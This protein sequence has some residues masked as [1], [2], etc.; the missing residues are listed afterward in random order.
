MSKQR[1]DY[2]L[3]IED[4]LTCIEKIERYTSNDSFEEFRG[5]D[6]A[7]DAVI[8]NFEIIGEAVKKIPEKIRLK[9]ADV[10]WKEAAGFR[11]IL[12]HDY[13]G[14][15]LEAVWDTVRNNIP[16]FKKQ[17]V[18]VLKSEKTLEEE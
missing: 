16:S 12:I 15:D 4:I 1:E 13:F 14:I 6:M 18:K 17:V 3:F 11:D 5:N 7:V 9:Y 2:I 10:E 8:R